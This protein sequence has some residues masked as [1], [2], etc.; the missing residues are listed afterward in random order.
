MVNVPMTAM[1]SYSGG[2]YGSGYGVK[3]CFE[4]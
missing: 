1:G 2:T 4:K 3:F